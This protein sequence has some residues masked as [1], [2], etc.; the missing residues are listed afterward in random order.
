MHTKTAYLT[1]ES[2]P[3]LKTGDLVEFSEDHV[4]EVD[5]D[6]SLSPTFRL[7]K[8]TQPPFLRKYRTQKTDMDKTEKTDKDSDDGDAHRIEK[9]DT[10]G[11]RFEPMGG[12]DIPT[13]EGHPLPNITITR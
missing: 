2:S 12:E 5:K 13:F 9:Y 4:C 7:H 11:D 1:D 8:L 3:N 10:P 6:G